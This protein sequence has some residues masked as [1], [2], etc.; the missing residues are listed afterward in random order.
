MKPRRANVKRAPITPPTIA[1]TFG[2]DP[3]KVAPWLSVGKRVPVLEYVSQL[4]RWE[5]EKTYTATVSVPVTVEA[6][7]VL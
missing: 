5:T 7:G 3:D 6:G 4:T 2:G 1:A